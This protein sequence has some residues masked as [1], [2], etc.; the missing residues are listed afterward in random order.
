MHN[1]KNNT[2]IV[3]I[4]DTAKLMEKKKPPTPNTDYIT[5]KLSEDD[6]LEIHKLLEMKLDKENNLSKIEKLMSIAKNIEK[7]TEEYF[8]WY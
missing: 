4:S 8:S 6:I 1:I 5:L 7:Q 2:R 3:N